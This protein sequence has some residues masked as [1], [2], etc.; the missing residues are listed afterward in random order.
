[1]IIRN[2]LESDTKDI[3]RMA[4]LMHEE[5]RYKIFNYDDKKIEKL[6]SFLITDDS[7]ILLVAESDNKLIGGIMAMVI[8]HFFGHD[9]SSVDFVLFV[10]PDYRDSKTAML[11]I[12][13]Y[14]NQ[15]RG[16]GAVD[17]GI[18]NSTG[19]ATIGKLYERMGFT[20]VG[21]NYRLEVC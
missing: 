17:I 20:L 19:P 3:L 4:K 6:I 7:G 16:K 14:I 8:E 13:R 10:E 1:M 21:G 12:K 15:A 2:A 18:G 11:L 5:S 9:K